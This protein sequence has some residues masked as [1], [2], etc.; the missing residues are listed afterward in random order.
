[1]NL[2]RAILRVVLI[3]AASPL[4]RAQI[5]PLTPLPAIPKPFPF[6]GSKYKLLPPGGQVVLRQTPAPGAALRLVTPNRPC[7]VARIVQP[8][9]AIDPQIVAGGLRPVITPN[10]RDIAEA[11]VPAP[12]CFDLA[13]PQANPEP[14]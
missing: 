11:N 12:S 10:S 9:D 13:A 2:N 3:V 7:A 14:R 8:N 1:M 6:D 5:A 4:I